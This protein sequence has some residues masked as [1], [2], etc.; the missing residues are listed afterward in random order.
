[1]SFDSTLLKATVKASEGLWAAF[2]LGQHPGGDPASLGP[3]LGP[4]GAVTLLRTPGLAGWQRQSPGPGAE[5]GE[6]GRCS[7]PTVPARASVPKWGLAGGDCLPGS[8]LSGPR[9]GQRMTD[10]FL[11]QPVLKEGELTD[12]PRAAGTANR[13]GT[14]WG[15]LC[16]VRL[17]GLSRV[18]GC[19]A[20][21]VSRISL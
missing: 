16:R 20:T 14:A 21:C 3:Q 10:M 11:S 4:R 6:R 18:T 9:A 2:P 17:T 5:S 13:G 7:G 15:F 12:G 19:Q 1:M 8:D